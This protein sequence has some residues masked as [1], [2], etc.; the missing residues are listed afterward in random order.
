[1]ETGEPGRRESLVA[2]SGGGG[3]R[4]RQSDMQCLQNWFLLFA[5]NAS[6]LLVCGPGL[7]GGGAKQGDVKK[8][9]SRAPSRTRRND[10]RIWEGEEK[11]GVQDFSEG[12]VEQKGRKPTRKYPWYGN[13]SHT[14][15]DTY[16]TSH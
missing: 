15:T 5:R 9:S 1:M 2:G 8:A 14:Q 4:S 12:I 6:S 3:T 16:T 10:D 7:G 11:S 13:F